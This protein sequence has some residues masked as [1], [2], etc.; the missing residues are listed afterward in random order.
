MMSTPSSSTS[1]DQRVPTVVLYVGVLKPHKE[2]SP[3]VFCRYDKVNVGTGV[4]IRPCYSPSTSLYHQQNHLLPQPG[5]Y[6]TSHHPESFYV[7]TVLGE[8]HIKYARKVVHF[9]RL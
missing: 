7:T 4:G 1:Q 5:R 9:V 6:V 3:S 2:L 8:L